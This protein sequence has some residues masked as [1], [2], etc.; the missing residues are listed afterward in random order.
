[1][2]SNANDDKEAIALKQ[3]AKAF[4]QMPFNRLLGLHLESLTQDNVI[5]SFN[6]KDDLVGNFVHRI[7]H[8][9]V[10]S[11]VLDM[12]GG[13]AAMATLIFKQ[14]DTPLSELTALLGK[15]STVDLHVSYLRP[16][17]GARFIATAEVM[18]AGNQ[19][20]F[21][22]MALQN[23]D[24]TLIASGTGTYLLGGTK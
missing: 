24:D 15:S 23:Q 18:R 4:D 20:C 21:T 11:S 5:V 7:L 10:I 16:G 6:M 2:T 3:L 13:M 1:M 17:S 14:P 22:K 19:I 8:G 9:G 12:V